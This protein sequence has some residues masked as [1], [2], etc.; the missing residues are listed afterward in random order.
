MAKQ[1]TQG[2]GHFRVTTNA[3]WDEVD[4]NT[5]NQAVEK[6]TARI[7]DRKGVLAGSLTVTKIERNPKPLWSVETNAGTE[8]V[9]A[10]DEKTAEELGISRVMGRTGQPLDRMKVLSVTPLKP[11]MD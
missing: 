6:A 2:T 5:V 3:G 8:V 4:A 7:A 1:K 9:D 10:H 11:G